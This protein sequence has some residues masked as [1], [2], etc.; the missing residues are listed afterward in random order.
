MFALRVGAAA[1]EVTGPGAESGFEGEGEGEGVEESDVLDLEG[2]DREATE[3]GAGFTHRKVE[4]SEEIH[5][6]CFGIE[7][8]EGPELDHHLFGFLVER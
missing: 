8:G 2:G 5:E 4:G 1:E 7:G 3:K 6:D